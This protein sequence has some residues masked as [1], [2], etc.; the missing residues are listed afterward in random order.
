MRE[1]GV[2]PEHNYVVVNPDDIKINLPDYKKIEQAGDWRAAKQTHE[3]SSD[4]ARAL[5]N[6]AVKERR[7]IIVDRTIG[8]VEKALEDIRYFK[9]QGYEVHLYGVTIDPSE[10]IIR[11]VE[12]YYGSGRLTYMPDLVK[13]HKGFNKYLKDYIRDVDVAVVIDNT[14]PVPIDVMVKAE[15]RVEILDEAITVKIEK[16]GKLNAKAVTHRTLRKSQGFD[17]NL[18]AEYRN[19]THLYERPAADTGAGARTGTRADRGEASARRP[20]PDVQ[21][22]LKD[23]QELSPIDL[24]SRVIEADDAELRRIIAVNPDLEMPVASR[25][26]E[27]GE[28][29]TETQTVAD[30]FKQLDDAEKGTMDL[31]NCYMGKPR[32]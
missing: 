19:I 29:V 30:R 26:N 17:E 18:A 2:L 8:N 20:D 32:G 21:Q 13:A 24:D 23:E 25:L 10:A 27:R 16:R 3:E 14:P 11:G 28:V 9:E 1:S 6:Q 7:H 31:F 4:I 15:G 5:Q 12:R 22:R